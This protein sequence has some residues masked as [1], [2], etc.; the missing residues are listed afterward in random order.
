MLAPPLFRVR[1]KQPV[2]PSQ[3]NKS[4]DVAALQDALGTFAQYHGKEDAIGRHDGTLDSAIRTVQHRFGLKADGVAKPGG[5]TEFLLNAILAGGAGALAP[6]PARTPD[7]ASFR[8]RLLLKGAVG[9]A[10][11]NDP[12]DEATVRHGLALLGHLPLGAIVP[13]NRLPPR[14]LG[15]GIA[16]LLRRH[17]RPPARTLTPGSPAAATLAKELGIAYADK[18]PE[19][20]PRPDR[21]QPTLADSAPHDRPVSLL[22]AA[23]RRPHAAS[24]TRPGGQTAEAKSP[25][26]LEDEVEILGTELPPDRARKVTDTVALL[27]GAKDGQGGIASP[28]TQDQ[29]DVLRFYYE[30]QRLGRNLPA[31]VAGAISRIYASL[32]IDPGF[33]A[34][35]KTLREKTFQALVSDRA[36]VMDLDRWQFLSSDQR[37]KVLERAVQ[38]FAD[39]FG[40]PVVPEIRSGDLSGYKAYALFQ[41]DTT[42]NGFGYITIDPAYFEAGSG[43]TQLNR[44]VHELGHAYQQKLVLDLFASRLPKDDPRYPQVELFALSR[45]FYDDVTKPARGTGSYSHDPGENHAE[46]LAHQWNLFAQT[47]LLSRE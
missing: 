14:A 2:G 12:D 7:R 42:V 15:D 46:D 19:E 47:W 34:V 35:E 40:L 30:E 29:L 9:E 27:N 44:L 31:D 32:E 45:P 17:G 33:V 16:R 37:K 21:G 39:S 28:S 11:H 43:L 26:W 10:G 1:L 38:I 36:L 3:P 4:D 18:L 8:Q 6:D 23:D 5:P 13:G 24:D 25:G 20:A 41:P 22:R